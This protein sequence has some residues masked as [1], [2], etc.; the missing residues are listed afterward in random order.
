MRWQLRGLWKNPHFRQ[1]WMGR[2]VSNLGNCITGIA[3]PLTAVLVLSATPAQMSILSALN[4]IAVLF[5]GLVAGVWVDRL[6]RRPILIATDL[7]RAL[8]ISSIPAA[9]LLGVL[10]IEQLYIVTALVGVLTVFFSAADASFLP[11][12]VQSQELVEGNSKLGI[13]DS[14]AEI[15]GPALGGLLVQAF[16]A[17]L[18][19]VIDTLTFLWSAL[20]FARIRTE[21]PSIAVKQRR[22]AWVEGIEG[23]HFVLKS[24]QLRALAISAGL[25]NFFGMF[26][27]TLYAFY[28]VRELGAAPI[29]LGLLTAAG[30]LSA[31]VGAALAERV[32]RRVGLGLTAGAA[33]A[34]YGLMGLLLPLASG[35]VIV[36]ITLLFISQLVGDSAISI[37]LIA[38][39]SLRQMLVPHHLLGR[40]NASFQF[41]T[42]GIAPFGALLA[43]VI[44]E[45]GGVRLTLLIGVLGVISAGLAL[46][47]SPV[48]Q[49]REVERT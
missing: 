35:P 19:I 9:A 29:I 10:H 41:L 42:L 38:E 21:E 34:I 25:F 16:S 28:V 30:G 1:L 33:L 12:L 17:P 39:L 20:C 49:V 47:F 5:F 7:G 24:P 27:G 4:G 13:S 44:A 45:L 48:R 18:A 46:L 40:V 8:L 26:I 14:L 31:L 2:I 23:L 32:I 22:N 36:V 3:L 15:I 11:T 43:G 6:R 37:H